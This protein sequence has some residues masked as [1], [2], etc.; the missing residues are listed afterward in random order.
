MFTLNHA[1]FTGRCS[2]TG[3]GINPNVLN[4]FPKQFTN[5]SKGIAL[6]A[7]M[8]KAWVPLPQTPTS[9]R[10]GVPELPE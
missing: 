6:G 4:N 2:G 1:E 5:L 3:T 10:R 7:K 9:P 8:P